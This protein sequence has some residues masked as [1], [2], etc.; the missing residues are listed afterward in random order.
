[1]GYGSAPFPSSQQ[2]RDV[3][4]YPLP[5]LHEEKV[6]G[7]DTE[8]PAGFLVKTRKERKKIK[9]LLFV[10]KEHKASRNFIVEPLFLFR[11]PYHEE[12]DEDDQG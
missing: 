8:E 7:T 10:L 3:R 2:I 1:M 4:P 6:P 9:K 12:P 11:E 5:A